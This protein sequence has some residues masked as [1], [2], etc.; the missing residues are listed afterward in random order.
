[1]EKN[2]KV[3]LNNKEMTMEEFEEKKQEIKKQKGITLVEVSSNN[4]KTRL[5]G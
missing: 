5:Q 2:D 1:M 3:I 4:Y